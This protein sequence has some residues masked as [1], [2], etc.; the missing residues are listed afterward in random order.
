MTL[1]VHVPRLLA[2]ATLG[3]ALGCGGSKVQDLDEA[4]VGSEVIVERSEGSRPDWVV[5]PP[6]DDDGMKF[7]S[8]GEEGF[9]DYALCL[10]MA[11]AEAMQEMGESV[12]SVW[13]SLLQA[14][15]VGGKDQLDQYARNFQ[16]LAV[17]QVSMS[18][19]ETEER[20]Y[21]KVAVKTGYGVEYR[22]NGFVLL[23]VP[24]QE[25]HMA[26]ARALQELKKQAQDNGD[27][28]AEEFIDE[29]IQRLD[30]IRG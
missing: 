28:T 30:E 18:G 16:E 5:D 20:Y 11:K 1:R 27:S 13:S 22:Y 4:P 24:E 6:K 21:E 15:E 7:F 26:Q 19:A 8:G 9:T 10:R 14:S 23:K 25:Y 2:I 29:A 17:K 3:A 12:M